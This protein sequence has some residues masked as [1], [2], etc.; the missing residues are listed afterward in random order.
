MSEGVQSTEGWNPDLPAGSEP[1]P[2]LRRGV[3]C[4]GLLCC[5]CGLRLLSLLTHVL[6]LSGA[7]VEGAGALPPFLPRH[8]LRIAASPTPSL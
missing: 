1:L 7:G 2:A 5:P 3:L 6:G 8:L 4:P